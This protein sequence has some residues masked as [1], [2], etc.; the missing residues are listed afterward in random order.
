MLRHPVKSPDASGLADGMPFHRLQKILARR[1]R[2]EIQLRVE[3]VELKHVAMKRART[4]AR[5][6]ITGRAVGAAAR[7]TGAIS[8]AAVYSLAESALT[9]SDVEPTHEQTIPTQGARSDSEPSQR[10]LRACAL[11]RRLMP[12]GLGGP[13]VEP[14]RQS[15]ADAARGRLSLPLRRNI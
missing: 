6:E 12:V 5:S 4:G 10:L 8:R 11:P 9:P 15:S 14:R 2:R 13:G 7:D 1:V 3:S